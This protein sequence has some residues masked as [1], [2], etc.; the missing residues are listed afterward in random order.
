MGEAGGG[1]AGGQRDVGLA[2]LAPLVHFGVNDVLCLVSAGACAE[3]Q[4]DWN[5]FNWQTVR[6]LLCDV[7]CF[8]CRNK[9][10]AQIQ[11]S[12]PG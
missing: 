1:T 10:V 6:Q 8:T 2:H 11:M 9:S 7:Q 3:G 5:H 4:E 12:R